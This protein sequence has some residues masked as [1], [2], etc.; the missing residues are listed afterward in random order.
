MDILVIFQRMLMLLAM[1][2]LGYV[3]YKKSWLEDHS[4][5]KLSEIIVNIFNPA[6][7]INGALTATTAGSADISLV[8]ENLIYVCIYFIVN[9]AISYPIA[10]LLGKDDSQKIMYRLMTIF[11]NVGFM[12]IPVVSSI[13]GTGSIIYI[14]FYMLAYNLILYTLGIVIAQKNIPKEERKSGLAGLFNI[15]TICSLIAI[16][17]YFSGI[18]FNDSVLSFFDYVGSATIPLSMMV[19]GVSVAKMP[20]KEVFKGIRVYAFSIVTLLVVPIAATFIFRGLENN[21]VIFGVFILM[22]A[23]PVGSIV[24]MLIKEYGGDESF[25][26]RTTIITTLL[27]IITIPIVAYFI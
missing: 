2:G 26:S 1:M 13:Y 9:I 27:S 23:M 10:L 6:L 12:G 20:I 19:I 25:A 24:T 17:I 5:K 15:G 4:Y 11:S 14:T 22:F 16:V 18:E 21:N 8:K 3:S 7:V